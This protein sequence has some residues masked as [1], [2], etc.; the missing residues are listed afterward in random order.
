MP[1]SL[2]TV[3]AAGE[4]QRE[5]GRRSCREWH[6]TVKTKKIFD[7]ITFQCECTLLAMA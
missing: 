1:Y 5:N 4:G 2:E 3:T 7:R 6:A